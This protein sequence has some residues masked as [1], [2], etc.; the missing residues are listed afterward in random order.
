MTEAFNGGHIVPTLIQTGFG[1]SSV[2]NIIEH[3]SHPLRPPTLRSAQYLPS[4][5]TVCHLDLTVVHIWITYALA[6]RRHR[7][8][9]VAL[10]L[11]DGGCIDPWTT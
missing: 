6:L 3:R 9:W 10:L 8:R 1:S 5:N 7:L 2:E 11:V 4:Q